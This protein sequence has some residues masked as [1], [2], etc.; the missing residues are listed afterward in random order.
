[1]RRRKEAVVKVFT[2]ARLGV[3]GR[4]PLVSASDLG[5]SLDRWPP[6]G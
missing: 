6:A 3:R 1:M 2:F 4:S 5:Q